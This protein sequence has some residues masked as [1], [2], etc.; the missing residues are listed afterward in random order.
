MSNHRKPHN[1]EVFD[2]DY[3][4]AEVFNYTKDYVKACSKERPLYISSLVTSILQD[5][6]DLINFCNTLGYT[7]DTIREIAIE[8]CLTEC[9]HKISIPYEYTATHIMRAIGLV[10]MAG[11]YMFQSSKS[12]MHGHFTHK[13]DLVLF[14]MM[15]PSAL[16]ND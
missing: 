10:E 3:L 6:I 8:A 15:L 5:R 14:R 2:K 9:H 7:R 11:S 16:E 13:A 4:T 1:T 12:Q